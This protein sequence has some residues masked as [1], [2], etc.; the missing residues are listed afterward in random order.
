MIAELGLAALWFA[1][2]LAGLQVIAG[3]L[4]LVPR[5]RNFAGIV[6][7][8]AIVQGLL[9]VIAF[10]ALIVLFCQTDLSVKLVAMNSHSAKPLFYKFADTW[11]NRAGSILLW[12][13]MMGLA[14]A[15]VARVKRRL[16]EP[17][18]LVTLVGQAFVSLV[19]YAFL[20]LA[21]NPFERLTVPAAEGLALNPLLQ[22]PVSAF[23]TPILYFGYAGFVVGLS[24]AL[25]A[26]VTRETGMV[27]ARTMRPWVLGAWIFLTLGIT[28]DFCLVSSTFDRGV[29]VML[30]LV[31]TALIHRFSVSAI[32]NGNRPWKV[33]LRQ[34]PLP[35]WGRA[36]AHFGI[37]VALFG[38]V[39]DNAFSAQRMVT[40]RIGEV[41]R[42]GPWQ[43]RLD[44]IEPVAGSGWT[45]LEGRISARYNATAPILLTPQARSF[46][47]PPQQTSTAA[48]ATRWNGQLYAVLG[49][50]ARDGSWQLRLRWRPFAP[51]IWVGGMLIALGG[52]LALSGHLRSDLRRIVARE[53]IAYRRT[54]Q[55]R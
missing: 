22:N 27:F 9:A 41:Q 47:N 10:A 17:A 12:L 54:R 53:K 14:G 11:G 4:A 18:M 6:R 39:S 8:A 36:I 2:A 48:V 52:F 32:H 15:F 45:A 34:M 33:P 20:L 21:S 37:A 51:M 43:I 13:T 19:F 24:F 16:P 7:P 3:T 42:L 46:W 29:G 38:L 35:A 28:A 26:L 49:D 44:R 31:A 25:G 50:E 55:G 23:H 40:A 1:A 5:G 30:W